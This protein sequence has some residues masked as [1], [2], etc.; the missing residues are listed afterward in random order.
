MRVTR[1]K[2]QDTTIFTTLIASIMF[3]LSSNHTVTGSKQDDLRRILKI[4]L[5]GTGHP[6]FWHYLLTLIVVP[7]IYAIVMFL[8][9]F[10]SEFLKNLCIFT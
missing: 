9:V 8:F 7:N 5:K 3:L 4:T 2:P 6:N 10:F 1:K